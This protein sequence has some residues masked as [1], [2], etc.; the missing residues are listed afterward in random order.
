MKII[1]AVLIPIAVILFLFIAFLLFFTVTEYKPDSVEKLSS[2]SSPVITTSNPGGISILSWNIGYCGLDRDN[3]FVMEGGKNSRAESVEAVR[4]SLDGILEFAQLQEPDIYFIQEADSGSRRSF[5]IDQVKTITSVL[6]QYEAWY[7]INYKSLFVPYPASSPMGKVKSGI[8]TLSRFSTD[9]AQ[10]LSLPGS[11]GWPVKLFHLKRCAV[12]TRFPSAVEGKD[13]CIVNLHLSA[14]GDGSMREQQL[15][16][17]KQLLTGLYNEG[18]YVVAG[19]D[20]NS[21]FPGMDMDS[22]GPY[23]TPA[24]NLFWV[25]SIPDGWTPADWQW[26]YDRDIPTSRSLEKPYRGGENFTTVIDG[27]LVSPNLKVDDI[28]GFNLGFE[29]TDHNPVSLTV[30]IR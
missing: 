11:F 18:H 26:C 21:I 8:L 12:I 9:S 15:E 16:Y 2:I 6:G 20:W 25:K 29:Y 23:T 17:V 3:D 10:R 14:Y 22:F 30:S 27:F 24:E 1:K 19:G 4:K 13:W 7:G 28:R 5:N